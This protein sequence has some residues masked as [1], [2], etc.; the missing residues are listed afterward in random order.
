MLPRCVCVALAPRACSLHPDPAL[1]GLRCL[2]SLRRCP[3]SPQSY[4]AWASAA[5]PRSLYHPTRS[6]CHAYQFGTPGL[7]ARP[8]AVA[9]SR[10][11]IATQHYDDPLLLPCSG[12]SCTHLLRC[13]LLAFCATPPTLCAGSQL[14]VRP[15]RIFRIAGLALSTTGT[16]APGLDTEIHWLS[17]SALPIASALM[18]TFHYDIYSS[19][20]LIPHLSYTHISL[21]IPFR[22]TSISFGVHIVIHNKI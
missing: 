14:P 19:L 15:R 11:H 1:G 2:P 10:R 17:L 7:L 5:P 13:A 8:F 20:P 22:L 3:P 16:A 6:L 12:S 18:R 4:A 9:T 21:M